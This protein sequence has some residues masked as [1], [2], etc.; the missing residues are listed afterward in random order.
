MASERILY[1][2][3]YRI[4]VNNGKEKP[5]LHLPELS[6]NSGEIVALIGESGAG[7]SLTGLSIGGL[8]P[9]G[10]KAE[11][12]LGFSP[13]TGREIDVLRTGHREL[14]RLRALELGFVMQQPLT[15]FNPVLR[16]R[17]Q[18]RERIGW[19]YKDADE[20]Q[21]RLGELLKSLK[22]ADTERILN[23][24]PHQLSGG[25]LQRIALAM[26]LCTKPSLIVADEPT[27]ALDADTRE[28][29]L[30]LLIEACREKETALL[31]ITHDLQLASKR[32]DR[33][34][35]LKEGELKFDGRP[36]ELQ[37]TSEVYTRSLFK[38]Y[39]LFYNNR[40]IHAPGMY[41]V[42]IAASGSIG[43][44]E[45]SLEYWGPG[46]FSGGKKFAAL[47]KIST[48]FKAGCR[49]G[50]LGTTGSGK[51]SLAKILCGL[52]SPTGGNIEFGDQRFTRGIKDPRF[53]NI[54]MIFQDAVSSFNPSRKI[55]TQILD[56]RVGSVSIADRFFELMD[57]CGLDRNLAHRFPAQ[58]SGGQVQRF[59]IIRALLTEPEGIVF[60][61][62]VTTLDIHWK[63]EVIRLVQELI[64]S[65][66]ISCWVI[67][68]EKKVLEHLCDEIIRI[69]DGRIVEREIL[70]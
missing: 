9:A 40:I 39:D 10:L 42:G 1:F 29:V 61:E 30:N 43:L 17:K 6:M 32:A 45:L 70:E 23:S 25:Q 47:K 16:I 31:L 35:V 60:D 18:L 24:Y 26:A 59:A 67:S 27:S 13:S 15:S 65:R 62:F 5:L 12:R 41:K 19:K 53:P 55:G 7:K 68:H 20:Q 52:E 69:E 8:L 21:R 4:E 58:L 22:F 51:S 56:I 3:E 11:G 36:D 57:K 64:L 34:A 2:K 50:I 44:N 37:S 38:K 54:Q 48:D 14:Q 46:I 49:T 66:G 28:E 63:I 33:I